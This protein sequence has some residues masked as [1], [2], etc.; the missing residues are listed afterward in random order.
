MQ[1]GKVD[2]NH[3][4][5]L[6]DAAL[7]ADL[8]EGEQAADQEAL[9]EMQ[10]A[11]EDEDG[12]MDESRDMEFTAM[13]AS[14]DAAPMFA[15]RSAMPMAMASMAAPMAAPMAAAAPPS[16]ELR[17][18]VARGMP[19]QDMAKR[20]E[21]RQAQLYRAPEKT[22]EYGE[23]GYFNQDQDAPSYHVVPAN[24]FWEDCARQSQAAGLQSVLSARW[25]EA[26]GSISEALLMMAIL[27]VPFANTTQAE[28]PAGGGMVLRPVEPAIIFV[29]Q[30]RPADAADAGS[31]LLVHQNFFEYDSRQTTDA[32]GQLVDKYIRDE[33]VC[34]SVRHF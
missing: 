34:V 4:N 2:Q 13:S 7:L 16:P 23:R 27:D 22:K 3:V 25:F 5:K 9:M 1:A 12:G 11:P 6:F 24:R 14:M 28:F 17:R 18:R 21:I 29:R 10:Q 26:C 20:R 32:S 31:P 19:A 33:Y 15:A 8:P 30:I